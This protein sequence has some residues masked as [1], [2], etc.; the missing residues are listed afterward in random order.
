MKSMEDDDEDDD[1]R[2]YFLRRRGWGGTVDNIQT[3]FWRRWTCRKR[4]ASL[5]LQVGRRPHTRG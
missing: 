4:Y 2:K 3:G 5:S 1:L